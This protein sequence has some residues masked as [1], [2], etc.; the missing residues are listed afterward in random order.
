MRIVRK[1]GGWL[2]K[3]PF[4]RFLFAKDDTQGMPSFESAVWSGYESAEKAIE[5][6]EE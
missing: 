2:V 3:R 5:I 1:F 4:G 6:L